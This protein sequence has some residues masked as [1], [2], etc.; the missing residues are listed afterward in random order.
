MKKILDQ[1]ILA[2]KKEQISQYKLAK[3]LNIS[4]SYINEILNGKKQ[5]N[6]DYL[7]KICAYLGYDITLTKKNS[8][9]I[10][11]LAI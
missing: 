8:W 11:P 2:M 5:P 10:S 3:S 6:M 9:L 7:L 1:I 4:Q